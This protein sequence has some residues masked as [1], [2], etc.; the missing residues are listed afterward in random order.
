MRSPS[1][2]TTN[3]ALLHPPPI[4]L[5]APD[6]LL[7]PPP[8]TSQRTI[9]NPP[10][11]SSSSAGDPL[12]HPPPVPLFHIDPLPQPPSWSSLGG[13]EDPLLN[14][15]PVNANRPSPSTA[16]PLPSSR[17]D[18]PAASGL[19]GSGQ[20]R[21]MRLERMSREERMEYY[22]E[23]TN[24]AS[25]SCRSKPHCRSCDNCGVPGPCGG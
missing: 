19:R 3:D 25:L 1:P 17:S 23:S 4:S 16:E 9:L 14:P 21:Q 20:E 13:P 5:E 12:R 11:I 22:C 24:I 15:P 8:I 10:V 7:N 18:Q 2:P 6:P